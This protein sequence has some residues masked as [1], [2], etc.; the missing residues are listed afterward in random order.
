M[1]R[2]APAN[3]TT[4]PELGPD[5][6]SDHEEQQALQS[7]L[8][9]PEAVLVAGYAEPA[10]L[11]NL[12]TGTSVANRH[13][14]RISELFLNGLDDKL[15]TLTATCI[16]TGQLT[17]TN[18]SLPTSSGQ[19][20]YQLHMI[21]HIMGDQMLYLFHD[22]TLDSNLRDALIE[23]RQR[24]KDLVE[25]SSDFC[26]E[27]GTDGSFDF[28][29]RTGALGY[30]PEEMIGRA[31]D[32]FI[33]GA[34][35]Y[36]P[37]PF[38]TDR[39]VEDI[40]IWMNRADGGM[41]CVVVSAIPFHDDD[42]SSMGVRGVC[43]DVTA[44]RERATAL[45][46]A[47]QREQVLGYIV[48]TIRD[49]INPTDMLGAAAA[50]TARAMG[51]SGCRILRIKSHSET[52]SSPHIDYETAAEFGAGGPGQFGDD[53]L[54]FD[55]D[56]PWL[57]EIELEGWNLIVA[58]C[59]HA[60]TINGVICL[61]KRG[62]WVDDDRLLVND[63][64]N[65]LGIAIEQIENHESILRLSRTDAMTGLLNRRAFYDEE[66]PRHFKRLEHDDTC[67]ALFYVD[68]DNFK[69]V[70]DVHGHQKG[71]EAIIAL[72]DLLYDFVR[73]G[74]VVARLG[75]DE[76]ALWLDG[77]NEDTAT[78]RSHQLLKLSERLRPLSGAED[79]PLGIS[80]GIAVYR[81][82]S[83]ESLESLLARADAA[84]YEVKQNA[85]GDSCL[86]SPFQALEG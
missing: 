61:W 31:P 64:S 79:K 23:S 20:I 43:R 83:G 36:D 62:T 69:L 60:G 75:G 24:F 4:E 80:I 81:P 77:M 56:K 71:D 46:Q 18:I 41:A 26:W 55:T 28:V 52:G 40:E 59:L 6:G 2:P 58:P 34:D 73:P 13:A 74:D 57:R 3:P 7:P 84:M 5:R 85:K 53:V 54:L 39:R 29:S 27:V 10:V 63:I 70:N 35:E 12:V 50:A 21:P 67:G 30:T 19:V 49:E 86:A 42:G 16:Q 15:A 44:E 38:L 72:R 22:Q 14:T 51:A 33:V 47:H 17:S 11:L 65:Q 25:V 78:S 1:T 45:A 66:L 82:Q 76:F 32:E 8:G 48:N 68:M 37:I 9:T